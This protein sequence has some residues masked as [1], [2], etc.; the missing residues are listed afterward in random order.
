MIKKLKQLL[1]LLQSESTETMQTPANQQIVF[2][3]KL[4]NLEVGQL[5]LDEGVW[6]YEYSDA[7]KQQNYIQPLV[8]FPTADRVY[9]ADL[10]WP[11][12][13]SRI[14]STNQPYVKDIV[15]R[16]NIDLT[17]TADML[18]EFGQRTIANPFALQ[19]ALA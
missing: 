14:P 5:R 16:K 8:D 17:N 11:F 18:K 2:Y 13:S 4:K 15:K 19:T 7:F 6:T 9:E 10:L 12:F 1:G 3:L